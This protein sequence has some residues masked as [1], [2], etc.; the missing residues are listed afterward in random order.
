MRGE[1]RRI[2]NEQ[3]SILGNGKEE[4]RVENKI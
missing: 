2:R 3:G 4:G 1:N